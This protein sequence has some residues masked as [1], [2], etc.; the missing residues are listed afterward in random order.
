MGEAGEV[1]Q[2]DFIESVLVIEPIHGRKIMKD[3]EG[4]AGGAGGGGLESGAVLDDQPGAGGVQFG[5][6]ELSLTD[7][8]QFAVKG[9]EDLLTGIG[10]CSG[11]EG[12]DAEGR[13]EDAGGPDEVGEGAFLANGMEERAGHIGK[14]F[15]EQFAQ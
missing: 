15:V 14:D 12:K 11:V 1:L 7:S 3:I 10:A 5:I 4:D 9:I 13:A 6:L 2:L 8:F